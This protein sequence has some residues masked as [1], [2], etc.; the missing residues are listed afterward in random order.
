MTKKE[1]LQNMWIPYTK[2]FPPDTEELILTWNYKL[3]KPW[4]SQADAARSTAKKLVK[5]PRCFD[6]SQNIALFSSH[7]MY[8]PGPK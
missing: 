3:H 6:N 1:F 2:R 4:V 7:W 5:D 8:I